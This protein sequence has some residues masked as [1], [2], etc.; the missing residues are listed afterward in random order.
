MSIDL[1]YA[2][3]RPGDRPYIRIHCPYHEDDTPSLA[4]YHDHAWCYGGCGYVSAEQLL[5]TLNANP[6]L[7][8]KL[9][10]REAQTLKERADPPSRALIRVWH[11]TLVEGPRQHRMEWLLRRGLHRHTIR[12]HLLGHTGM[13]FVIPVLHRERVL[14]YRLRRDDAYCDPDLPRYKQP[15]GQPDLLFRPNPRGSPTVVCEGELDALLLAQYGV[16]AITNTAGS[17]ALPN[18]IHRV[19][20]QKR[21]TIYVATDQDDA[22]EETAKRI[23]ERFPGRVKRLRWQGGKDVTEALSQV[24]EMDRITTLRRWLYG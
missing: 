11:R 15:V 23:A 20:E 21:G 1:R 8:P 9:S 4:V 3:G 12:Q 17:S 7:L 24:S 14:G 10:P 19:L 22:G 6:D 13:W 16:D 18:R 5:D 2:V